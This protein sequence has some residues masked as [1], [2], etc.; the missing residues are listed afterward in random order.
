MLSNCALD[1]II[2]RFSE[3]EKGKYPVSYAKNRGFVYRQSD[4]A[5][6]HDSTARNGIV[7]IRRAEVIHVRKEMT[8]RKGMGVKD[9]AY[10]MFHSPVDSC[11]RR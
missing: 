7:D 2:E 6:S 1:D 8:R 9:P 11:S 10:S 4:F 3:V 5:C